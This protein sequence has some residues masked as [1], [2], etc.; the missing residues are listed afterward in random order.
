MIKGNGHIDVVEDEVVWV[1]L[2]NGTQDY[3]VG[4]EFLIEI[5]IK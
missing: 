1:R 2:Y 5:K 3:E 4:N